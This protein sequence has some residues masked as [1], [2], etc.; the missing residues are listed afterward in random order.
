MKVTQMQFQIISIQRSRFTVIPFLSIMKPRVVLE[1]VAF[2]LCSY[3]S[4]GYFL[5]VV[6]RLTLKSRW[7]NMAEVWLAGWLSF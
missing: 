2:S 6:E 7:D 1:R 3:T 4:L 5:L